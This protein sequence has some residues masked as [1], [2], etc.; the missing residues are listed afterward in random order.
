MRSRSSVLSHVLGSN[1][2]VCGYRELHRRYFAFRHII[3][4]RSILFEELRCSLEKKYLLDKILHNSYFVSEE[5]IE[6]I[7]PKIIFLLREPDSSIKS[8]INLGE[9]TNAHWYK[10][11][12]W[13]VEYYCSR[14]AYMEEFS[15][16]IAGAYL[17]IE[18]D[19]LVDQTDRVLNDLSGWLDLQ[20]PLK[21][22][23]SFFKKTGL[24]GAGDSSPYIR[25]GVIE[26]TPG[27][28]HISI[29]SESLR[30][31]YHYYQ[32]CRKRLAQGCLSNRRAD[33]FSA[34]KPVHKEI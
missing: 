23:Y 5:L 28:P 9:T 14:L 18:S 2:E 3:S 12:S 33:I 24:P 4:M 22:Q 17:F 8:I 25:S 7:K 13:A 1:P 15:K 19:D 27:Y 30:K 31:S 21:K 20:T 11:P 10:S 34:R 16:K 32:K 26:K 6:K 29:P